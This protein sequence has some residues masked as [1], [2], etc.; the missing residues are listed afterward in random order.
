MPIAGYLVGRLFGLDAA[1]AAGLIL[2]ACCP[3]GTASNVIA[4]IARADVALSVSMTL[5]STLLAVGLT[6]FLASELIGDRVAVDRLGLLQTTAGVVLVPVLAG[7]TLRSFFPRFTRVLLPCAPLGR[8]GLYCDYCGWDYCDEA[9]NYPGGG[10][11]VDCCRRSRTHLGGSA[12]LLD[13]TLVDPAQAG[14]AN[15]RY[16]SGNAKRWT[17]KLTGRQ[18]REPR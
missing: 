3:G 9:R 11:N 1:F 8:R 14:R 2:V 4:Y 17:G 13:W 18:S 10:A 7:L 15:N 12:G 6:P 5:V 16:R